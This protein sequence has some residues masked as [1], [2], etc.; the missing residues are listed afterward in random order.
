MKRVELSISV[1]CA[2][3]VSLSLGLGGVKA[4]WNPMQ[5][6]LAEFE[7][8]VAAVTYAPEEYKTESET[9]Y[10]AIVAVIVEKSALWKE[11]VPAPPP[12]KPK[13]RPV[14]KPDLKKMLQGVVA[15]SR[16]EIT[17]VGGRT[18]I[19]VKTPENL[20]GSWLGVGDRV[21][22]LWIKEITEKAVVFSFISNKKEYTYSLPRR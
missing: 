14:K 5:G 1:A 22:R 7:L 18:L 12:R 11:L 8:E 17:G 4:A 3:I 6:R 20:K 13:P 2:L 21:Q 16:L 15:S 10:D 19:N 9:N